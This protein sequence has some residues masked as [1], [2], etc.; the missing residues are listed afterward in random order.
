M[1]VKVNEQTAEKQQ[2]LR[3]IADICE[4]IAVSIN[5]GS[6]TSVGMLAYVQTLQ[7][8]LRS[9]EQTLNQSN[10][11]ELMA[12]VEQEMYAVDNFSYEDY[13]KYADNMAEYLSSTPG[14]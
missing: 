12:K 2:E 5:Y 4:G 1:L 8:F 10:A 11:N 6:F 13:L 3:S 14:F 7:G 9:F